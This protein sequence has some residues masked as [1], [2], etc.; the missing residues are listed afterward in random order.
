MHFVTGQLARVLLLAPF[1]L[2]GCGGGDGSTNGDG[3][4]PSLQTNTGTPPPPGGQFSRGNTATPP[5][6]GGNTVIPPTTSGNS[7]TPGTT[8]GGNTVAPATSGNTATP[9][10]TNGGD[11]GG[12]TP[13]TASPGT[14]ASGGTGSTPGTTSGSTGN[15]NNPAATGNARRFAYVTGATGAIN[16]GLVPS[17]FGYNIDADTG[18]L[19]GLRITEIGP[20]SSGLALAAHPSGKFLYVYAN[21]YPEDFAT[22]NVTSQIWAFSID[23]ATGALSLIGQIGAGTPMSSSGTIGVEPTGQFLYMSGNFSNETKIYRISGSGELTQTGA[24]SGA[25]FVPRLMHPSGKFA[26]L[27]ESGGVRAYRIDASSGDLIPMGPAQTISLRALD[28]TGRFAYATSSEFS[29]YSVGADGRLMPIG[30][31]ALEAG[32]FYSV[33]LGTGGK[34]AYVT[35]S[36]SNS[37]STYAIGATGTPTLVGTITIGDTNSGVFD[38]TTDPSGKFAYLSIGSNISRFKG[39]WVYSIDPATGLLARTESF[40]S[41][42]TGGAVAI[43]STGG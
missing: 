38:V 39:V 26:Y 16:P 2:A 41:A 27:T 31:A 3:G 12:S 35:N 25:E 37:V 43:V 6:T 7:A 42:T 33:T 21:V 24:L 19:N 8:T 15:G 10:V 4:S 30:S 1:V 34:F 14:T 28:P 9:P 36:T 13:T 22:S 29:A 32:I 5:A 11:T 40:V 17:V 23:P 18:T 20:R